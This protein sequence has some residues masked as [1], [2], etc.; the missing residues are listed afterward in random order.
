MFKGED[1]LE[2]RCLGLEC[3]RVRVLKLRVGEIQ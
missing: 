2:L 1:V 3:P